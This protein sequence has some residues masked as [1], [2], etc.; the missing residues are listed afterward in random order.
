MIPNKAQK[1]LSL[2]TFIYKN[3]KSV[4]LSENTVNKVEIFSFMMIAFFFFQV[5]SNFVCS[6]F[7]DRLFASSY[8]SL[9]QRSSSLPASLQVDRPK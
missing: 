3:G 8:G 7:H 1:C 9:I 6:I 5:A 4:Q 2:H